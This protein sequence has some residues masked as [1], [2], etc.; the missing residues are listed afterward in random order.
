MLLFVA[1]GATATQVVMAD[2]P[3]RVARISHSQGEVSYSPYGT[4]DWIAVDRNRA[5]W[6]G[7]RLWA[8]CSA[9]AEL[10][11]GNAELRLAPATGLEILDLDDQIAQFELTQGS[12][13]LRVSRLYEGQVYEI[14][15]PTLAFTIDQPGR[16]RVDV[17]PHG[18]QTTI[19]VREGGGEAWGDNSRFALHDGDAVRF[20]D[21]DLRRYA[22]FDLPRADAFDRYCMDRDQRLDGSPSLRH[23]GADLIGFA[24]LDEYGGWREVGNYGGV[25]FPRQVAADWAPYRDGHWVWQ[26]PWGWTWVDD[27]PWGFAP[28]HYG[29][30]VHVQD[31]WGWIPGP[32]NARVVYAPALVAFIGGDNWSGSQSRG[33]DAPVGWFPLGPREVYVPTYSASRGYF[34]RVNMSN[35]V[36]NRT[37]ITTIY[38]NYSS[39]RGSIAQPRYMNRDVRGSVTAV[40]GSVFRNGR[41]VRSAALRVDGDMLAAGEIARRI[42]IAPDPRSVRGTAADARAR[43][44]AAVFDR[45]VLARHAAPARAEAAFD[46]DPRDRSQDDPARRGN[47]TPPQ[48]DQTASDNV[49]QIQQRS[50]IDARAAGGDARE[51]SDQRGATDGSRADGR[52]DRAAA[53]DGSAARPREQPASRS[54]RPDRN[55]GPAATPETIDEARTFERAQLAQQR[56][57]ER[58][59]G[60]QHATERVQR[61]AL[62]RQQEQQSI[63][64][65]RQRAEQDQQRTQERQQRSQENQ[66]R[67]QQAQPQQ[68]QEQQQIE[69]GRQ[70]AAQQQQQTRQRVQQEQ[71]QPQQEQQQQRSQQDQRREPQQDARSQQPRTAPTATEQPLQWR[72]GNPRR[73]Q[74]PADP[75]GEQTEQDK[76]ERGKRDD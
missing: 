51:R 64:Q 63:E 46:P 27:A 21:S 31:R 61:D 5:L 35:T 73:N 25:W 16:Y 66:L 70:R 6:R 14:A 40:P 38:N 52:P 15:T 69:Q 55:V 76:A 4:D 1:L 59:Q 29:R 28:S 50:M 45:R 30:W 20:D 19:I 13:N 75:D 36:V 9:L 44:D 71:Q 60:E 53:A 17:D 2:P 32:R 56:Q 49:R 41:G 12:V 47:P 62:Q 74:A 43:P 67:E 3:G 34:D 22:L 58:Q 57:I 39:G 10:Q 48:R 18:N 23:V 8:D 65:Q 24:D 33:N 37:S 7:D 72:E 26:D 68:M 11:V 42:D 54:D